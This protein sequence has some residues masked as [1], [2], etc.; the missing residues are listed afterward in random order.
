MGGTSGVTLFFCPAG[1]FGPR[2]TRNCH[3]LHQLAA[4]PGLPFVT[5]LPSA[6][7]AEAAVEL[8]PHRVR[9][10]CHVINPDLHGKNKM[11]VF[12]RFRANDKT[13]SSPQ[14][15]IMFWPQQA[16]ALLVADLFISVH[17]LL[18]GWR[19]V[20]ADLEVLAAHWKLILFHFLSCPSA[21]VRDRFRMACAER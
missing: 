3:R 15:Q 6:C 21:A 19:N 2:L 9:D 16:V 13:R 8:P 14:R 4:A 5:A 18:I 20:T 11:C 1:Y 10:F 7:P 17:L 12:C